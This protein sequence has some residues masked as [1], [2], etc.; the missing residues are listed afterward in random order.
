MQDKYLLPCYQ[1]NHCTAV[2]ASCA[3]AYEADALLFNPEVT[4]GNKPSVIN[5]TAEP[6]VINSTEVNLNTRLKITTC[7][8]FNTTL[9]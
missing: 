5:A 4:S 3:E 6:D 2:C 1:F 8:A 7:N 9:L